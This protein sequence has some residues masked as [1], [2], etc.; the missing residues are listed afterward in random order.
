MKM[1]DIREL[2]REELA[3]RLRDAREEYENLRFQLATH[4]LDNQV[5]VRLAR[6]DVARLET[7]LREFE[8]GLRQE[9]EKA[10]K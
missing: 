5:K 3:Q 6:R 9:P 2:T 8:L 4:Q 10:S 1:H 7:V